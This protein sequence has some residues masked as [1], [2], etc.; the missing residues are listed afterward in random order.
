MVAEA[1]AVLHCSVALGPVGITDARGA[2]SLKTQ[3]YVRPKGRVQV[4][5]PSSALTTISIVARGRGRGPEQTRR[6]QLL[7][8]CVRGGALVQAA[9]GPAHEDL[10]TLQSDSGPEPPPGG[11]GLIPRQTFMESLILAQDERWRRA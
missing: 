9:L 4:R 8:L 1:S 7:P 2:W 3:Q 11:D 10:T 5:P 6:V